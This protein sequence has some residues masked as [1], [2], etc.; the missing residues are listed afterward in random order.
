[1]RT[2][3]K[4]DS[5][6]CLSDAKRKGWS[7]DDFVENDRRGYQS[8]RQVADSEQRGEC[9][10]TELPLNNQQTIIH[11]DHFRKKSI[12]P[13]LRFD[14]NNLFA[15]VKDHRFGAG[16]KDNIVDGKNAGQIYC[17]VLSPL[18]SELN[19]YFHYATNGEI[20][21]KSGLTEDDKS[22]AEK[23]IE[24][25]NLNESELVSRRRTIIAQISNYRDLSE[26]DI[27][28]CFVGAG[29]SSVLDQEISFISMFT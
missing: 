22:R 4:S 19:A 15:A 5:P 29:F 26:S 12:Y 18:T 14:W 8:C 7:W 3:V 23:T 13:N 11:L 6:A 27:R 16:Y 1:M 20:E 25:F 21:P 10:Y 9:A 17:Q 2:I 28:D 24:L